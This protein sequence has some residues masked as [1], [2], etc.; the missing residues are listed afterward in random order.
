MVRHAL[1]LFVVVP[2]FAGCHKTETGAGS[3]SERHSGRYEG[4][5]I[6]TPGD[7]WRK[8]ADAPKPT[9]D[10]AATLDDDDY[11]AF[12][13][14]TKTGEVRECG[15]RSGFCVKMQP[16]AK[17]APKAPLA[18]TEHK[19]ISDASETIINEAMATE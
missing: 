15:N 4:V 13:T 17:P 2:V 16:W 9:S 8:L 19:R 18:L 14:D 11:V 3:S 1:L 5:G 10:K 6:A 12:V 7:Q